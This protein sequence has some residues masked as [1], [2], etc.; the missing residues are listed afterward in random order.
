MLQFLQSRSIHLLAEA[1]RSPKRDPCL[2]I[3]RIVLDRSFQYLDAPLHIAELRQGA[4]GIAQDLG[5]VAFDR[6][7]PFRFRARFDDR[8]NAVCDEAQAR[9]QRQSKCKLRVRECEVRIKSRSLSQQRGSLRQRFFAPTFEAD[10]PGPLTEARPG[11]RLASRR[12]RIKATSARTSSGS[13]RL[14]MA[15]TI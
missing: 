6:H 14:A 13:I 7:R 3:A 2:C 8:G 4:A 15:R 11:I 5:G 12:R 1:E 10:Q 9:A